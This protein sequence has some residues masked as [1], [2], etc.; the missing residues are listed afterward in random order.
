[1]EQLRFPPAPSSPVESADA[2]ECQS[3]LG[4]ARFLT[5]LGPHPSLPRLLG[6]VTAEMPQM[7]VLEELEHK[8]LLSFLWRCR[9]VW[10]I[11]HFT[12]Q[13]SPKNLRISIINTVSSHRLFTIV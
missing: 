12:A 11:A 6:Q 10:T 7:I 2:R 9:Q 3:F 13:R 1:M 4:F 8:D 5:E